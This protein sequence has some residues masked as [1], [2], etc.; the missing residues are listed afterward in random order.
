MGKGELTLEN[1]F[2]RLLDRS[3]DA[4][5][6][7]WIDNSKK[8]TRVTKSKWSYN[9]KGIE[10]HL[11]SECTPLQFSHIQD[12]NSI[13]HIAHTLNYNSGLGN[14]AIEYLKMLDT[15]TGSKYA[16]LKHKKPFTEN[17]LRKS[18]KQ[19]EKTPIKF[20]DVINAFQDIRTTQDFM[21]VNYWLYSLSLRGLGGIDICNISE[22]NIIRGEG[23]KD[24]CPILPYYPDSVSYTH[25]TLPTNREV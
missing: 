7:S 14:G 1:A 24:N 17:G 13:Q 10:K 15:I 6:K 11:G 2:N 5:I 22:Q 25:L 9:L 18:K 23:I 16:N 8:L 3:E 20:M 19:T 21:A 4:S 12:P